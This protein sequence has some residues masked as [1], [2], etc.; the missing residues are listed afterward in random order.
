MNKCDVCGEEMVRKQ[1][2]CPDGRPGCAVFHFKYVCK[3][4]CEYKE[5]R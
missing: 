3:N 2:P 5:P 4:M 1:I